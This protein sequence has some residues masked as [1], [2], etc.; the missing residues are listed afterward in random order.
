MNVWTQTMEFSKYVLAYAYLERIMKLSKIKW[1]FSYQVY[2]CFSNLL[3]LITYWSLITFLKLSFFKHIDT[4]VYSTST[5]CL[6]TY[7]QLFKMFSPFSFLGPNC[8]IFPFLL[9]FFLNWSTSYL[10]FHVNF[11]FKNDC[12]WFALCGNIS[13]RL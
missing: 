12:L 9:S 13:R 5:Y 2:F 4:N 1:R 10:S 11:L 3:L 7:V 6:H 8:S